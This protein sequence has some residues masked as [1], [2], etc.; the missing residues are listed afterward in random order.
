MSHS[1]RLGILSVGGGNVLTLEFVFKHLKG[2]NGSGR[3]NPQG[4]KV[5]GDLR[6]DRVVSDFP[7]SLYWFRN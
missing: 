6:K 7:P 1:F 3:E 5:F 2:L 4:E